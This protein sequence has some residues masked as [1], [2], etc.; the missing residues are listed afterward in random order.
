MGPIR[1]RKRGHFSFPEKGKL[2]KE[3]CH[4]GALRWRTGKWRTGK[5]R[6]KTSDSAAGIGLHRIG[7]FRQT[8]CLRLKLIFDG[9]VTVESA[10]KAWSMRTLY[11]H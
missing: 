11:N 3:G 2:D 6:T 5:C 10:A 4:S 1:V 8:Y 7:K 9:A